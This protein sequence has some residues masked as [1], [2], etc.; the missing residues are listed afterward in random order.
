MSNTAARPTRC[1]AVKLACEA[2]DG[3]SAEKERYP[4]RIKRLGWL[5]VEGRSHARFRCERLVTIYREDA[6]VLETHV[7]T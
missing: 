4:S 2:E 5:K 3:G 1:G 7:M 6:L